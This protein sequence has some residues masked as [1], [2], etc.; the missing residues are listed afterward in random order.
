MAC[1]IAGAWLA[2]NIAG[3]YDGEWSGLF[4]T[5]ADAALP[6]DLE[7]HTRRVD[8]AAGYDGQFYHLLA[9]D[10]LMRAPF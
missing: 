6:S 2:V 5:G 10:P 4:Y 8:D 9:H 3:A 7:A 1:L